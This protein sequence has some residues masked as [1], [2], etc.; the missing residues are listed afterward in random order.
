M[1]TADP[2]IEWPFN[3]R[4]MSWLQ[5]E[6]GTARFLGHLRLVLIDFASGLQSP[7]SAWWED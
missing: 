3:T 5:D 4:W 1:L 6:K 7:P 2:F